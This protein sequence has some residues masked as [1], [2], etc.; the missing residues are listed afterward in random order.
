MSVE[1]RLL[2]PLAPA[3]DGGFRWFRSANVVDL[4]RYRSSAEKERIR[5]ALLHIH[6]HER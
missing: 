3:W 6:R 1:D 4:Q 5:T 2:Y